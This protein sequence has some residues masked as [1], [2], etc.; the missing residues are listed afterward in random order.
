MGKGDT[1]MSRSEDKLSIIK[2]LVNL[3]TLS[4]EEFR[5]VVKELLNEKTYKTYNVKGQNP[6][7]FGWCI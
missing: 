2:T 4:D 3:K 6:E 1:K 7:D 5:K